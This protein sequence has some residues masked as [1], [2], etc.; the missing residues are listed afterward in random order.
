MTCPVP[1]SWDPVDVGHDSSLL[2]ST[3][4]WL[5]SHLLFLVLPDAASVFVGLESNWEA[6]LMRLLGLFLTGLS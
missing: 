4:A 2:G 3:H 6:L 1:H 5:P